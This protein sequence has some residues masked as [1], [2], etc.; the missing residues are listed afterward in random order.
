[1]SAGQGFS[2]KL[3]SDRSR[4]EIAGPAARSNRPSSSLSYHTHRVFR[5]GPCH[6][7]TLP[8]V[9]HPMD[10][11][12]VMGVM[13]SQPPSNSF[14][15]ERASHDLANLNMIDRAACT[16]WSQICHILLCLSIV[17]YQASHRQADRQKVQSP[18]QDSSGT[19]DWES[20]EATRLDSVS[21]ANHMN[22][23]RASREACQDNSEESDGIKRD[24][25]THTAQR[26]A[27]IISSWGR[28][29]TRIR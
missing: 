10:C 26:S 9:L 22:L 13:L 19:R 18:N 14:P 27:C 15:N 29:R 20:L 5:K 21:R 1:M 12:E 11:E 23:G 6:D 7:T 3:L 2:D 17:D 24:S 8:G 4:P 28:S 25:T 16:N